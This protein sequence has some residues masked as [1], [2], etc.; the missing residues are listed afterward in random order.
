MNI[1]HPTLTIIILS[2]NVRELLANCLDSLCLDPDYKNWQIIIVDNASTDD[3]IKFLQNNYKTTHRHNDN[4]K[5]Q[6]IES[7]KNLGF[8]AGNNLAI[9]SIKAPYTLFLNPDTVVPKGTIPR[10]LKYLHN[11]PDTGAATCKV[12]LPDGR[13]DDGCHRGFPNPHNAFFHFTKLSK[14]F[15]NSKFMSEYTHGHKSLNTIHQI[16]SLTGTF[17]MMPTELGEKLNWWDEDYFWNG[18]DLDFCYRIDQA[19]YKVMFIPDVTIIHYKGASGGYKPTSHGVQKVDKKTKIRTAKS[20]TQAMRI[21]YQKHYLDKYPRWMTWLTLLG[22]TL[23]EKYRIYRI[24]K[25]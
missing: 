6:I 4:S 5:I 24:N 1:K 19:G 13:L 7:D 18:D 21:F 16:D 22:I 14:I 15:P 17:M 12:L 25:L 2:Y 23:L 3:T 8:S 20:S 10:I 9:S 11:H